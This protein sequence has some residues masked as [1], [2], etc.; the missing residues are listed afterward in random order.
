MKMIEPTK[1]IEITKII[2][3]RLKKEGFQPKFIKNIQ[4]GYKID[5]TEVSIFFTIIPIYFPIEELKG[6]LYNS[7]YQDLNPEDKGKFEITYNEKDKILTFYIE[8]N[9][10]NNIVRKNKLKMMLN[11]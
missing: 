5:F 11:D 6:Y 2:E 8:K 7:L 10:A 9:Y 4:H 1:K 3:C